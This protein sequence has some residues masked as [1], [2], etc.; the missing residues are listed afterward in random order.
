MLYR[1]EVDK[2]CNKCT[3]NCKEGTVSGQSEVPF[4]DVK[5]IVVS[6][7][8]G[9]REYKTNLSLAPSPPDKQGIPNS[10]KSP[11]GAGEFLRFC[12]KLIDASKEISQEFKPIE[13]FT[14]FTNAIKC[15][16]Q[17][18][19]DKITVT[20]RHIKTCRDSWLLKEIDMF[21]PKVP[22]FVCANEAV[23]A[24]LGTKESLYNNRNRINYY[25][26]HPVIV[27]TNPVE[28]EK[29]VMKYVPDIEE[30]RQYV[31]KLIKTSSFP[32]YKKKID[33]VI[34]VKKWEALPGSPLYFVK[35]DLNLVKQE[36]IKYINN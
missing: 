16:P 1:F 24:L 32:K 5:L 19:K 18:G 7:Y 29:Y 8:P 20:E 33:E 25:K 4:S 30:S 23:K 3:L 15:T 22:I 13:D 28:W 21:P 27:S 2:K 35:Q 12:F 36:I 17:H 14:Y 31:T 9:A 6:A 10:N 26:E 11:V 34:G